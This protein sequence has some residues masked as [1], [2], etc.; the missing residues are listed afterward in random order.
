MTLPHCFNA[1]DACDP[2][3]TYFRGQGWYRRRLVVRNPYP[4]GRTILHFQGAGQTTTLW[5]GSTYVVTHIGGYDEFTFDITD[6][7]TRL[8]SAERAAG[9]RIVVLCNNAPDRD[10]IPSELSDFC[11]Y[12][13]LYRHVNLIYLPAVA[14]DA[15]HVLPVVHLGGA[16]EVSV[17]ARLYNPATFNGNCN[18]AVEVWNPRGETIHPKPLKRSMPGKSLRHSLDSRWIRRICGLL[19]RR[20]SIVA[21]S[22]SPLPPERCKSNNAS[23]FAMLSLL[24]A[25]PFKLNGERISFR[26][27]PASP[28][29]KP[30]S[31][32]Q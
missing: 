11:L 24:N 30:E 31:L 7:A 8:T 23:A 15:V 18:V 22:L 6:A 16:A 19:D 14:L 4:N 2:D 26:G 32:R 10:R 17:S 28:G 3:K 25:R 12:G 1:Q 13:G 21:G 29:S 20:N 27:T 5:I 9:V